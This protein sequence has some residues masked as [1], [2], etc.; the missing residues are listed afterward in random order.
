MPGQKKRFE[1]ISFFP[2][3]SDGTSLPADRDAFHDGVLIFLTGHC[4]LA[5]HQEQRIQSRASWNR[6]IKQTAEK[7]LLH[8]GFHFFRMRKPPILPKAMAVTSI[9]L[10]L[11]LTVALVKGMSWFFSVFAGTIMTTAGI[12]R[13][14]GQAYWIEQPW[15]WYF[16]RKNWTTLNGSNK[17]RVIRP[18]LRIDF[19]I[20]GI[21]HFVLRFL[22][23][24]P[25]LMIATYFKEP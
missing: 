17:M 2:S 11:E 22:S 5:E 18:S 3:E 25:I 19:R 9:R 21:L 6:Q 13:W 4:F 23:K 1:S 8:Q 20:E 7:Q 10:T 12:R 16:F 24:L 14:L 15:R